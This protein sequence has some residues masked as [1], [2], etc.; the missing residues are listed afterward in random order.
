M[1]MK[2]KL[3]TFLLALAAFALPAGA[4]FKEKDLPQTLSVLHFELR[5][6]YLDLQQMSQ[7]ASRNVEAQH[8][9]LIRLIENCNELSLMLYSQQQDFTFDLTYALNEVTSQYINFG[10][11]RMPYNEII[12]R[13]EV[14]IDRYDKLVQTLKNLPPSIRQEETMTVKVM[15]GDSLS[16]EIADIDS[17]LTV[18]DFVDEVKNPYMLDEA[19]QAERDSCLLYAQQILD[20]YWEALLNVDEDNQHYKET[21]KHLKDAYD[22]AQQRYAQV[23]RKIFIDGQTPYPKLLKNFR[24]RWERA[25]KDC[26]DKYSTTSH[27]QRIVSEWRGPMVVG[28][29]LIV[30][31][32]LIFATLLSV[33]LV[34]VLMRTV[35]RL[36]N[37]YL[38][39]HKPLIILL[40]AVVIFAVGL[41]VASLLSGDN[42][43]FGMAAPLLA[44]FAWMLAAIFTSMLIRLHREETSGTLGAYSPIIT[45]GLIIITFRILFVPNSMIG[46]LFPPIL[47]LF[48]VWQLL[49][50][51]LRRSQL[52]VE[53]RRYAWISLTILLAGTVTAVCG[54]V[55]LALVMV[56][57]WIFQLTVIQTISAVFFLMDRYDRNTIA[58]RRRRY[59]KRHPNMPLTRKGSYIE[60]SWA[61]DLLRKFVIPLAIVWSIPLCIFMAAD[62]FDLSDVCRNFFFKSLISIEDVIDLSLFKVLMTI[63]L[64]FLFRFLSYLIRALYR[65]ARIKKAVEGLQEGV[66]FKETDINFTL[67][68][69]VIALICWALFAIIAFLMLKIPGKAVTVIATGLVTG[70]GFAL[71]DVLNNFFY[72]IQLM[73]GRMR[74]GDTIECD[75]IRGKVD[76]MSYQSTQIVAGDGYIIAFPNSS[77]F[78]KNF[79]NLTRNH[80]Y[81]LLQVPVGVKYGTD[82]TRV[83]DLLVEAVMALQKT[84]KFGSDLIQT[85]TGVIVRMAGFG[86]N[87]VDLIVQLHVIVEEYYA[88]A[89]AVREVVY[90][91][92]NANG[93]EIPFPQRDLYI[94][95]FPDGKV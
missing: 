66:V 1:D 7:G 18:P 49:E 50:N 15:E 38:Q 87:S 27:K 82:I 79:K 25:L 88:M 22:Y 47:L 29:T 17:L 12:N 70:I 68:D 6:A 41:W 10:R 67:A 37:S 14:E 52:Q 8:Q 11:N 84:D 39:D 21:D 46:I 57:W 54:Y 34:Q 83:R 75:G 81:Q 60:V 33:V 86:D 74:V 35:P 94:K 92:L 53:D 20:I 76:S 51:I 58:E 43:F 71:R 56:I 64:F 80:A 95:E 31:V 28:F 16:I 5:G 40:S 2:K 42:N 9:Q 4:V 93:I 44:E 45:M 89:A 13:F 90:N 19:G 48:S 69:N 63:S 85:K 24:F 91:T 55:M 26:R 62:V 30:L 78:A 77:L 73:S 72:G 23:Q 36:R 32:Y 3:L 65:T 61:Y 59:R